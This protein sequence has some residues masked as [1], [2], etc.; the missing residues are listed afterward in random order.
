MTLSTIHG[1]PAQR[2]KSETAADVTGSRSNRAARSRSF[3]GIVSLT[4]MSRW[5]AAGGS[6]WTTGA[7]FPGLNRA[8]DLLCLSWEG[9]LNHQSLV[10]L[11]RRMVL[12][13]PPLLLGGAFNVGCGIGFGPCPP[14]EW[15]ETVGIQPMDAG[16]ADGG[17]DNLIARCQASSSDCTPLCEHVRPNVRRSRPASSSRPTAASPFTSS[18]SPPARRALS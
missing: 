2:G 6:R 16:L 7:S 18:T 9:T 14:P 11:F 10:A 8:Y 3:P 17:I 1:V 5:L 12:A 15:S 13:G 4:G